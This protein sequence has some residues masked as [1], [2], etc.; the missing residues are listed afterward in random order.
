[1]RQGGFSPAKK[2][3]NCGAL[4]RAAPLCGGVFKRYNDNIKFIFDP[5][6]IVMAVTVYTTD[7]CPWCVK[8][9]EFLSSLNVQYE[10]KNVSGDK[11]AAMEMVKKTHQM[12][13]PVTQIGEK[14]IVGYDP[15]ALTAELKA[16]GI[17][18]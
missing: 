7:T 8:T 15:D 10:V 18:K 17:I 6:G 5:E 14:F 4:T 13:V 3:E 16:C 11:A 2:R 12:G 1:V 9:K